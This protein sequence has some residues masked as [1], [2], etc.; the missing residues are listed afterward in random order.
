MVLARIEIE[1]AHHGGKENGRLPV[2]YDDFEKYG[3]H[4]HAIRPAISELVAFGFIE[5]TER[6]RAGNAEFRSPNYFRLTYRHARGEPGDGTHEWRRLADITTDE[7]EAMARRARMAGGYPDAPAQKKQKSS[8]GKRHVSVAK[9]A[10]ENGNS[11]VAETA[12]TAIVRKPSLLSISRGGSRS[13]PGGS[14]VAS[15]PPRAD[16]ARA[17]AIEKLMLAHKCS[18]AEAADILDSMPDAPVRPAL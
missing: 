8:G 10:T 5:V 7:A 4:R 2:T 17:D 11:P 3:I 9:T 16:A 18:L 14:A 6:G 1:S 13:A 15:E 12:T